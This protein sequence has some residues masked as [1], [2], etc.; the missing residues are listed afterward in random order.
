MNLS[1]TGVLLALLFFLPGAVWIH[2]RQKHF[3]RHKTVASEFF[4]ESL[5]YATL[6]HFVLVLLLVF[7][8]RGAKVIVFEAAKTLAISPL[9]NLTPEQV[10]SSAVIILGY[11]LFC[12]LL[13]WAFSSLHCRYTTKRERG[14]LTPVWL[15]F[16][17][18]GRKRT[19]PREATFARV[20]MGDG[21]TYIG[22]VRRFS[23]SAE[24]IYSSSRDLILEHVHVVRP[25]EETSKELCPDIPE[26]MEATLLVNTKDIVAIELVGQE[27]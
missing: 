18:I 12:C 15:Y 9:A 10:T 16:F 7:L 3:P 14:L 20:Q 24:Q 21:T 19:A 6:I 8:P 4:V 13:A 22:Q 17:G 11:A 23:S 5:G 25:G 2:R 27:E 1:L 26:G